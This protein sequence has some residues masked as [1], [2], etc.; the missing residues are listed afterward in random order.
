MTSELRDLARK[1]HRLQKD[2]GSCVA[3]CRAIVD[4]YLGG[5]GVEEPCDPALAGERDN[6]SV[7]VDINV[8][9]AHVQR[10]GPA[11]VTVVPG[12]WMELARLEGWRSPYG[13]LGAQLHAIVIVGF[14][15]KS[16]FFMVLD[17]Y[18][19]KKHQPVSVSRDNF[20]IA[21]SGQVEFVYR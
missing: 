12:F 16:K 3:A 9:E 8:I 15:A 13:D 6:P 5:E 4:A 11:I 19:R 14:D 21:W 1:W 7:P 18:F 17:P 2:S 20:A 10:Y